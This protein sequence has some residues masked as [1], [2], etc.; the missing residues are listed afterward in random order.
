MKARMWMLLGVVGLLMNVAPPANA[1]GNGNNGG[2]GSK[3]PYP[4]G[5]NGFLVF[6]ATGAIPVTDSF[7]LDGDIFQEQ[8]MKRCPAEIAQ[9]RADALDYFFR[10]APVMDPK[11][12][13]K[14]L[15]P[16][17]AP[18]LRDLAALFGAVAFTNSVLSSSMQTLVFSQPLVPNSRIP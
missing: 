18:R 14:C 3:G 13:E 2:G 15:V 9:N 17:A 4:D 8:I 10:D 5:Y 1:D 7:F 16:E 6:M 11:A 12:V